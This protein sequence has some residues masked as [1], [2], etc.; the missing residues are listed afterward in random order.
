MENYTHPPLEPNP[1]VPENPLPSPALPEAVAPAA[2]ASA[3]TLNPQAIYPE[4]AANPT[5]VAAP[6]AA[7]SQGMFSGRLNRIG[8][9]L[10]SVYVLLPLLVVYVL[11]ISAHGVNASRG[12]IAGANVITLI[13][14]AIVCLIAIP[15]GFSVGIRRWHDL[16]KSGWFLLLSF[17]PFISI[18]V[19]I[20][21]IFFPGT[22]GPNDYGDPDSASSSPKKVLF[23]K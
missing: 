5:Q 4:A 7:Q 23:N 22:K 18:F 15:V 2:P 6:T 14:G 9:F 13:V 1:P 12:L 17:S 21:L 20:Y 10:A 3:P 8:Y 16:N 11:L 19:A